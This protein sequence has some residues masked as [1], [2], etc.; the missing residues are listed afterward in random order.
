[1][2]A[3]LTELDALVAWFAGWL[4]D[5]L[6]AAEREHEELSRWRD[7]RSGKGCRARAG[8]LVDLAAATVADRRAWCR[9]GAKFLAGLAM[10]RGRPDWLRLAEA[11]PAGRADDPTIVARGT[12][13]AE[14]RDAG[15]LADAV[16]LGP[17]LDAAMSAIAGCTDPT[18]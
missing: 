8:E 16:P 18:A 12:W 11:V 7:G 14:A 10:T 6:R 4:A 5:R 13:L 3:G 15:E 1:M 2:A 9:A 17:V